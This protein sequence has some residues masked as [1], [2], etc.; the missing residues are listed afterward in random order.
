MPAGWS[1]AGWSVRTA[2]WRA[3]ELAEA[4]FGDAVAA[5]L[6][7]A[8]QRGAFRGMLH[9]HVPFFDLD[10]HRARESRFAACA[11][12][13]PV[14]SQVSFVFVFHPRIDGEP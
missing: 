11:A 14:L 10:V 5:Q 8:S 13:D 12:A 4:I 3:R 7:G 1:V 2:Q 9:L 6:M